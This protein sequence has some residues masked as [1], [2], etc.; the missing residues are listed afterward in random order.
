MKINFST[1]L[2]WVILA[3]LIT[4]KS[5]AQDSIFVQKTPETYFRFMYENDFFNGTDYYYTQGVRVEVATPLAEKSPLSKLFPKAG[6]NATNI[7]GFF[8]EQQCYTPTSVSNYNLRIGDMPYAATMFLGQFLISADEEKRK[9]F[10]TEIIAGILGPCAVCGQEQEAIHRALGIYRP[11]G[12]QYQLNTSPILNYDIRYEKML[13]HEKFVEFTAGGYARAGTLYDEA[14]PLATLR[15]GRFNP[16]FNKDVMNG[17]S[18]RLKKFQYYAEIWGRANGVAYNST[19]QGG[20]FSDNIY[21]IPAAN[22]ERCVLAYGGDITV[23]YKKLTLQY[24]KTWITREFDNGLP[25]GWGGL[26]IIVR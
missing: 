10:S 12:W 8:I 6:D 13:L 18:R 21:T 24:A 7:H 19:L 3:L 11:H 1:P 14:G 20:L 16:G 17:L 4:L 15:V 2:L 25:H 5:E 26:N 23:S 22:I 9:Q